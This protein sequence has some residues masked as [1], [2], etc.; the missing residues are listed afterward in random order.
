MDYR[1]ERQPCVVCGWTT[2]TT[3]TCGDYVCRGCVTDHFE[4]IE[5]ARDYVLGV[6]VTECAT[7]LRPEVW[8]YSEERGA[9]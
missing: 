7:G 2:Y 6:N 1:T 5:Y 9:P 8:D 4:E 3:C